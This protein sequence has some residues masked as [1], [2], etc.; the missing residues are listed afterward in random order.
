MKLAIYSYDNNSE[1][2]ILLRN[3]LNEGADNQCFL[4]NHNNSR[5]VGN[6]DKTVINWGASTLPYEPLRCTVLNH[7]DRV[8][9][10]INKVKFFKHSATQE[11]YE[12]P[13]FTTDPVEAQQWLDAGD[14]VVCRTQIKGH[15]SAGIVICRQG[16]EL[17]QGCKLFTKYIKKRREFRVHVTRNG[18]CLIQEKLKKRDVQATDEDFMIRDPEK[19]AFCTIRNGAVSAD[20]LQRLEATAIDVIDHMGLDFGG[21]DIG[22]N[23][24]YNK[25]YV[26]EINT[27]PGIDGSD[28]EWYAEHLR[29]LVS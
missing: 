13:P 10:A 19:F 11:E 8:K 3:K 7:P 22:Y 20:L 21:V 24:H 2:A 18:R 29:Q 16:D 15:A 25:L 14:V 26:Y 6:I 23:Q 5:F 4:I 28:L 9:R 12:T 17:P 1:S 27:A